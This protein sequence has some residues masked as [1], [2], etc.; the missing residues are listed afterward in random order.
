MPSPFLYFAHDKL[1]PAEL[2]AARLDGHLVELGDAYF[3]ADAV[4]TAEMR[5]G[6]LAALLGTRLAASLLSAAWIHGALHDPPA[7]H[8]VCRAVHQRVATVLDRRL[9]FS[10]IV[11]EPDDL[12]V[13]AEVAVT[14]PVRTLIDLAR[15]SDRPEY[16]EAGRAL[17][18]A[19]LADPAAA[20]QWYRQR[21][22]VPD[23]RRA[24]AFLT[25]IGRREVRTK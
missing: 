11:L 21:P 18:A 4:E 20:A 12:I 7:R 6:S 15:R 24:D 9:V 17:V 23:A 3:P 22:R 25:D 10:D 5:A 19:G 8:T 2:S 16:A 14:T 1:S 13:Y